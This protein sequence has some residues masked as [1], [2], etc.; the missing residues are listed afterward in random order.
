MKITLIVNNV[1][2]RFNHLLSHKY[3]T[4]NFH[5]LMT[6]VAGNYNYFCRN[7]AINI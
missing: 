7:N 4:N 2:I 6:V 5:R 1:L 3:L